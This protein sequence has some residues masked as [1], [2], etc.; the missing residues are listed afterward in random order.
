MKKL[1]A[2]LISSLALSSTSVYAG[3]CDIKPEAETKTNTL[4]ARYKKLKKENE[5]LKSALNNCRQEKE[6]LRKELSH[7]ES[8]VSKLENEKSQLM[9]KLDSYPPKWRLQTKIQELEEKLRR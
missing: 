6:E 3:V 1:L 4:P 2:I 8:Q 5:E 7:L 9:E